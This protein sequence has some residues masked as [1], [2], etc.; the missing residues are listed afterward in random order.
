MKFTTTMPR[1]GSQTAESA[2]LSAARRVRSG[3]GKEEPEVLGDVMGM[4]S[5]AGPATVVGGE[6][7]LKA[8]AEKE[9]DE[10]GD[11]KG[12]CLGADEGAPDE[13]QDA[14]DILLLRPS[15]PREFDARA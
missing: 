14:N 12:A 9:P 10:L 4:G 1:I 2:A 15:F 11:V 3:D 13:K 8:D 6:G 7:W 5:R